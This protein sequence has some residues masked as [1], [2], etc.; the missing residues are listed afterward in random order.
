MAAKFRQASAG[1]VNMKNSF[2]KLYAKKVVARH[3]GHAQKYFLSR[4]V[5]QMNTTPA[6]MLINIASDLFSGKANVNNPAKTMSPP[7]LEASDSANKFS[8]VCR[9]N[10]QAIIHAA[11]SIAAAVNRIL[12]FFRRSRAKHIGNVT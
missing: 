4:N 11:T 10:R 1:I 2:Q 7:A 6:S 9:V 8:G 3:A 5:N 12:K